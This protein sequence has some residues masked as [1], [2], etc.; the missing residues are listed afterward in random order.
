MASKS[1][2]E[3]WL[4]EPPKKRRRKNIAKNSSNSRGTVAHVEPDRYPCGPVTFISSNINYTGWKSSNFYT[5]YRWS[6]LSFGYIRSDGVNPNDIAT[7]VSKYLSSSIIKLKLRKAPWCS[8]VTWIAIA[9]NDNINTIGAKTFTIETFNIDCRYGHP[10]CHN[11]MECGIFYNQINMNLL[12]R[13][14]FSMFS[15]DYARTVTGDT[16]IAQTMCKKGICLPVVTVKNGDRVTLTVNPQTRLIKQDIISNIGNNCEKNGSQVDH[17][18]KKN[19]I[20]VAQKYNLNKCYLVICIRLCKC[21]RFKS[22]CIRFMID[23]Q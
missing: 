16:L 7:I 19:N 18:E 17:H 15:F 11:Q 3:S 13:N 12:K 6:L 22:R 2:D 21:D 8:E 1:T 4:D 9:S 14:N 23:E 20:I 10:L 5:T